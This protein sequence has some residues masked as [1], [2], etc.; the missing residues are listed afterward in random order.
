MGSA[1]IRD[2]PGPFQWKIGEPFTPVGSETEQVRLRESPA[3]IGD[4]GVDLSEIFVC[5][6][7]YGRENIN[8]S[9]KYKMYTNS[10]IWSIGHG[11][12]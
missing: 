8:I 12:G 7:Y 3:I 4:G 9:H 1:G 11:T 10:S 2:S 5:S 6:A